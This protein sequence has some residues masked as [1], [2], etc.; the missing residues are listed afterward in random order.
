MRLH[1]VR[2]SLPGQHV[3]CHAAVLSQDGRAMRHGVALRLPRSHRLLQ[4]SFHFLAVRRLRAHG[5]SLPERR[6]VRRTRLSQLGATLRCRQ[7]TRGVL[8]AD[9]GRLLPESLLHFVYLDRLG[10]RHSRA[11]VAGCVHV[12]ETVTAS[13]IYKVEANALG[14]RSFVLSENARP[15]L[16]L[17]LRSLKLGQALHAFFALSAQPLLILLLLF[18]IVTN[19][20]ILLMDPCHLQSKLN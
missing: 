1:V 5:P 6:G 17:G 18:Y 15:P 10:T 3:S 12:D 13:A 11:V 4:L 19:G 16:L 20:Y 14:I 9:R 2:E 7:N 8:D